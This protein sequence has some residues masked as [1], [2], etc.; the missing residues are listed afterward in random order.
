MT[1]AP[2]I[3]TCWNG[4][5][6]RRPPPTSLRDQCLRDD[7]GR[8]RAAEFDVKWLVPGEC[9]IYALGFYYEVIFGASFRAAWWEQSVVMR[10]LLE[11]GRRRQETAGHANVILS[12]YYLGI[13]E[14]NTKRTKQAAGKTTRGKSANTRGKKKSHHKSTTYLNVFFPSVL[15]VPFFFFLQKWL[16]SQTKHYF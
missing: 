7:T 15:F 16:F 4:L 5:K 11:A 12:I 2:E 14:N 8:G 3:A 13:F 10:Q 6:T 9:L 1:E